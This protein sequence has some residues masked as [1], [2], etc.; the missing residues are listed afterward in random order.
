MILEPD[1]IRDE[2]IP[3]I[4]VM[5]YSQPGESALHRAYADAG[6][7]WWLE[8]LHDLRFTLEESLARVT[9]GP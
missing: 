4:V 2:T 5:G 1:E 9:S 8:A 6:A 7:T 3:E